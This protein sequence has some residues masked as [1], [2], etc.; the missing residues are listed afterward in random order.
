MTPNNIMQMNS[1][2]IYNHVANSGVLCESFENINNWSVFGG[3][4]TFESDAVNFT[5]GT[6]SLKLTPSAANGVIG[7][8]SVTN[9]DLSK[10]NKFLTIDVL[11][12]DKTTA[13]N[14]WVYF[15]TTSGMGKGMVCQ[16][17]YSS[18]A[19]QDGWNKVII[20]P[21]DWTSLGGGSWND[22]LTYIGVR[23]QSGAAQNGP[24]GFD[25]IRFGVR[26]VPKLLF[27]FDDV[28]K[29]ANDNAIAYMVSKG[30]KGTLYPNMD[31]VNDPER[32]NE[33]ELNSRYEI[34]WS[35]G[36]HVRDHT[37]LTTLATAE[38]IIAK[39]QP[40]TDWAL[41]KGWTRGIKSLALPAGGYNDL[42][43]S[44]IR[45]LGFKTIRSSDFGYNYS[46]Y[47]GGF[48]RATVL[49][50]AVSLATAKTYI[51]NTIKYGA[52]FVFYGHKFLAEP[53]PSDFAIANFCELIDYSIASGIDIVTEDQW[54]V[55]RN[56]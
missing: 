16:I 23:Y 12:P 55:S 13:G 36:N 49:S 27:V 3:A 4:G 40:Q 37:D 47:Y 38:E 34:G 53:A 51:D 56:I 39:I 8:R 20:H 31:R 25:N 44:T 48:F 7:V 45:G 10:W 26:T 18:A 50:T 54:E 52:T 5:E 42:V 1:P 15:C 35:I 2:L 17:N 41:L 43:L 33:E 19:Y 21:D 6:L 9:F 11:V 22:T 14:I 28:Y 24:R 32:M 30:L 29:S 46:P